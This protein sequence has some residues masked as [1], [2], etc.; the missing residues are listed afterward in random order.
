MRSARLLDSYPAG[1]PLTADQITEFHAARI[2]LLI[3]VCGTK[4]RIVGL[5]KL[6]KLDF[7]VRYPEFLQQAATYMNSQIELTEVAD[8]ESRMIRYHYGPWDP[9]YY[10]VLAF[11][12]ARELL[13]VQK[14]KNAFVFCLSPAG[15][16]RAKHLAREPA[17]S[18]LYTHMK[19]A[20]KIMGSK[21]GNAIKNIVYEIFRKEVA[22]LPLGEVISP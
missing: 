6:A 18:I 2:L 9:R 17:F 3:H 14:E 4:N 11:L 5:T 21:S 8:T 19:T 1:L 16:A 13:D 20:K 15:V 7:F 10:Q 22:N 12:E